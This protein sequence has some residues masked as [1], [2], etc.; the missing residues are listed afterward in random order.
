MTSTIK[1]K[2]IKNTTKQEIIADKNE[3]KDIFPIVV[4]NGN[5][6]LSYSTRC[7]N[8]G[9]YSYDAG[10][11]CEIVVKNNHVTKKDCDKIKKLDEYGIFNED[12]FSELFT[13]KE[14]TK[15]DIGDGKIDFFLNKKTT[16]PKII[17][18]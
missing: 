15:I 3:K 10:N 9:G 17:C 12:I 6:I 11:L 4:D 16:L 7:I 2:D 5:Y 14:V 1:K 18:K 13:K 8:G